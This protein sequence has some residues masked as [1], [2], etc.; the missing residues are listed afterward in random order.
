MKRN[1]LLSL[2]LLACSLL[3]GGPLA[4]SDPVKPLSPLPQSKQVDWQKMETYAFVH[5]GLNTF[6]DRE[7]GYGDADPK[8]FNPTQLDC[9]QWVQT[10]VKAGM[11]GVI[12][13]AKHHDGF[14]LWPTKYTDYSLKQ[15]PWKNGQGDL[16]G[17]LAKA[18]KKY[19]IKFAVYLSPWDRHQAFYGTPQ[20]VEYFHNQL[21]ELMT[22]YGDVFEVWFDGANGGD[23]WY[24]GAKDSRSID[25]KKYY[26]YPR[27]YRLL[28]KVQPQAIVFS[29]GGP[30]CRW[31]GNE[32]GFAG[33]TNWS[34]LRQ[35][36]VY[37]GYPNYRELQF[38][39]ADGNQWVAAE[40]DVSI[41]PGWFYH[42]KEDS[43]VKTVE[44]LTDLY[45]KSVGRNATLLLNFPVD[46][47]G[48]INA[49]DSTR[50]VTWHQQLA[51]ELGHDL[52]ARLAPQASNSREG[53]TY[54]PARTTDGNYDTYWAT[55]DGVT[56]ASLTFRFQKPTALNRILIQEYI[57]LGQRVKAFNLEAYCQGKWQP[58]DAG[59]ETTTVGYKR[60]LRFATVEAEQVRIHFTDAR[61]PLT[62][63]TVSAYYAAPAPKTGIKAAS[64]VTTHAPS[65][66]YQLSGINATEAQKAYDNNP[67]T[68]CF[69]KANRLLFD[70]KEVQLV[71]MLTYLP[72][73]GDYP[74]GLISSY[75]LYTSTPAGEA[76]QLVSKGEFSNI[77]SNPIEQVIRFAPVTARYL[78]LKVTRTVDNDSRIGLAE[79]G[80]HVAPIRVACVGNSITFG[81]TIANR[82]KNCYPAQ[83]QAYLGEGYE[84][85][86]FGI[87]GTT[88]LSKGDSPYIQ[89]KAYL[90]SQA[91]EPDIVL[92]KLGTNDSKP[93]NWKFHADFKADYQ[94]IIDSYK[95]LPSRPR[96]ILLAPL[97]SFLP[98]VN[99]ISTPN[100]ENVIRPIVEELAY[101]NQVEIV[102]LFNLFGDKWDEGSMPDKLH[103]SAIGAGRMAKKIGQY[104]TLPTETT[105]ALDRALQLKES[106]PFNF[107][108]YSGITF[109]NAGTRCMVVK[110]HAE[111]V[112]KPWV[113]RARFWGHEP[114]TDIDL[115]EQGFHIAYC[116]V[117]DLYGA[118]QA[119]A[120]W[121]SFYQRMRKAGFSPKVVLEGMSRGGL[122]VYT[123]AAKNPEKVACIYADAPV[124][125]F[126]SWPMGK[127]T[128]ACS[129]IDTQNLL[130]AY[131]FANEAAAL[132]WKKN[133]IDCASVIAKA[134]IP[135]LHVVG[136]ADETVPVAEN[137][138]IFEATMKKLGHPIT[139]IHKPGVGHHPH[140]LNNPAPIVRF[141][142]A[143]TGREENQCL[144]AVPGNE[145]RSAA[146]WVEGNEWYS[147]A[148]DITA[149]LQ[150][151][152]LELLLMG[153]SITQGWGGNRK[154][155]SY[156]PGKAAMDKALGANQWEAAGISGDRTQN[157]L[158]RIRHG[159]YNS[160]HPKHAVIAIGINDLI[161]EE[162]TAEHVAA[163]LLAIAAEA[164]KQ[165]PGTHIIL[166]GLLPSGKEGNSAIRITCNKIHQL[167][168]QT[169]LEGVDYVNP[170]PWFVEA[171][172]DM[173]EGLYGGD[174]IHLTNAGYE[175]WAN[176]IVKLIH[177]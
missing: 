96:L 32:N 31:V 74:A 162:E 5:F 27:I 170:T 4:A 160:C 60:I 23:G 161:G 128:A 38:G 110:P 105:T 144:H 61:G 141:I 137:T 99:D 19:G 78:L 9:E 41:R 13:T 53:Q 57:P 146:G 156:K 171:N 134:N 7:W 143:A 73:Q 153:N 149:T 166:M 11:K 59:E 3:A 132:K 90:E 93:K 29:D 52:F 157:L 100:I 18:C 136:D 140:S 77:K 15:S 26:D 2:V 135:V 10:F 109:T 44:H 88:L 126:K 167:L 36:E 65:L 14:C 50:A 87:S 174:Y 25:R 66:P 169:K 104:L 175:V 123:W 43:Q 54:T 138:A 47:T 6:N 45:Y 119:V 20:Y 115:L 118:P 130:K 30:G 102:N 150:G 168:A 101:T 12:F 107:H 97:R 155:V 133:P 8:T 116:D 158:W 176:E 39:H 24:G 98:G 82:E 34:F 64:T 117:A 92:I 95:K 122:I 48:R 148:E 147:V 46:R 145:F 51:A 108:G 173:K 67:A 72:D 1:S 164:K 177:N 124:M 37:P 63:N 70:L 152:Q 111:A 58:I 84:V 69:V 62:I 81:A 142:L 106:Q 86:N 103:P 56:S 35:G 42:A 80:F 131:H 85:K 55:A 49:I 165:L 75:E 91:F 163:G 83:L 125:D 94:A 71:S 154:A 79:W 113:I 172:G 21:A 89:T 33:A 159:A 121:D 139:V 114:Q 120:R 16:V 40:C 129:A 151:K 127:G 28:D 76:K 22:G 17:D 112:G 68:T